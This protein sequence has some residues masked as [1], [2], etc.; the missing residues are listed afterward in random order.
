MSFDDFKRVNFEETSEMFLSIMLMLQTHL[1]C[2]EN[3]FRYRQN[4][5][6]YVDKGGE[7][8]K[9]AEDGEIKLIASPKMMSRLAPIQNM[10][11]DMNINFNPKAMTTMLQNAAAGEG[12]ML[13]ENAKEVL[14]SRADLKKDKAERA[15]QL[16]EMMKAGTDNI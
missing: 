9:K 6:K 12:T 16:E 4:Y 5:S 7:E 15:K 8:E 13:G 3:F 11:S 2:S 10:A 1:P 14:L